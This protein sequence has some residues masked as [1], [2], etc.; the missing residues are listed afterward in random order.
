MELLLRWLAVGSKGYRPS[1]QPHNSTAIIITYDD[2]GYE[3]DVGIT[4]GSIQN[5]KIQL[6]KLHLFSQY[7]GLQLEIT[8]CE[9][10]RALWALG[11]PLTHKN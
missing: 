8:K 1:Y 3:D 10:T 5:L 11:N 6:S 2:H 9:A 7:I 4:T